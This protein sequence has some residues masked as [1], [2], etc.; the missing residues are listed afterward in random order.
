MRHPRV[1]VYLLNLCKFY[2]WQSRND[3]HFHHVP[4]CAVDVIAKVKACLK[5]HLPIFF[6]GFQSSRRRRYFHRQWGACGVTVLFFVRVLPLGWLGDII[7]I[8]L[9]LPSMCVYS[10]VFVC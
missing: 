9:S 5:S 10:S 4:P 3:F 6:K 1:F 7:I 8:L 2:I